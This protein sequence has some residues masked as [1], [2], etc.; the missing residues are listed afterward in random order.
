MD[1]LL[2]VGQPGLAAV[3]L[4]RDRGEGRGQVP[5]VDPHVVG[6][7]DPLQVDDVGVGGQESGLRPAVPLAFLCAVPADAE[8]V[9]L[10]AGV[11]RRARAEPLVARVV[12]R[13][14]VPDR[15]DGRGDGF[16]MATIP[17]SPSA[18]MVGAWPAPRTGL[19]AEVR[20]SR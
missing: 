19:T 15:L 18:W 9:R 12:I 5:P 11:E 20:L 17:G 14:R 1:A 3:A 16:D 7:H 6:E 4:Q 2:G 10:R 8:L 13:Q